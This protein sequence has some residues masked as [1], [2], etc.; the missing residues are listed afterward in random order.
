MTSRWS[1]NCVETQNAGH[2]LTGFIDENW[3]VKP[4]NVK[5]MKTKD[6]KLYEVE[7]KEGV[8]VD[9]SSDINCDNH[10]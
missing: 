7:I 9:L 10:C 6:M 1:A 5:K 2:L 3:E 8:G 4:K